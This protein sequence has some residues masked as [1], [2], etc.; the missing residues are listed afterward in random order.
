M[1]VKDI[2]L[3]A[4]LSASLTAGKIVLMA[5][6]NIEIVTFLMIAFTILFG[7][8]RAFWASI[9]FVTTEVMMYGFGTWILGYYLIW[10]L[11]IL[12]TSLIQ[13]K[14]TSEYAFAILSGIYGLSFGLF[15]A[16]FESF[17]YGISYGIAYWL[18]GIPFDIVHGV[19]NFIIVLVLFNPVI[20]AI[21]KIL[22]KWG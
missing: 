1:K 5:I 20:K 4:I 10:P 19:S 9:V 6:P 11:L 18:S 14:T 3:I 17:F 2:T 8:K 7:A 22:M 21:D 13:R 15:F 12:L 16:I